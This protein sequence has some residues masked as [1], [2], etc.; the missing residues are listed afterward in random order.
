MIRT[1]H[2]HDQATQ[3]NTVANFETKCICRVTFGNRKWQTGSI[4]D[5]KMIQTWRRNKFKVNDFAY[6]V[7]DKLGVSLKYL[8]VLRL[9]MMRLTS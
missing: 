5:S 7:Q 8:A 2:V 3:K 4:F 1:Y 9:F 6:R